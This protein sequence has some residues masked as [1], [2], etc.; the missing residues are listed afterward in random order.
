MTSIWEDCETNPVHVAILPSLDDL[1]AGRAVRAVLLLHTAEMQGTMSGRRPVCPT[2]CKVAPC[3][4]VL[5]VADAF[6]VT[7]AEGAA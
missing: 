5:V 4:S 7:V 1:P 2:C 3:V 6:G